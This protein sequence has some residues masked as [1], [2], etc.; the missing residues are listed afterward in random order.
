[1]DVVKDWF[2]LYSHSGIV[3]V[4]QTGSA[5]LSRLI[6]PAATLTLHKAIFTPVVKQ[7]KDISYKYM[8]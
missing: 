5:I 6:T 4:Y 2:T 7:C 8:L 1:M 3:F